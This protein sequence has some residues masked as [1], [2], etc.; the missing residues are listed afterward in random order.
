MKVILADDHDLF[1]GGFSLLFTQLEA[2]A[3]VLEADDLAGALKLATEHPDTDLLLLDLDMPGMNGPAS[4]RRVTADH[5]QLPVIVLSANEAR[6]SVQAAIAAGA[7]GF[8]PK[9]ASPAVMQSAVRLVLS[10]GVYLPVELI[11]TNVAPNPRHDAPVTLTGRQHDVLRLLAAG[12][13]N[14]QI[15]RELG[16]GEGTIKVHIAALFRALDVGNRTGAAH[17][18]RQLGLID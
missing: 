2:G 3:V 15:C 10:G 18:A 4:I 11:M 14:K 13:S 8:I 6:E 5:P 16:L 12:M 7:L 9:S 1:R 17:A